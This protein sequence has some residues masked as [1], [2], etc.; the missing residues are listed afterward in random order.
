LVER[1]GRLQLEGL[2]AWAQ[3]KIFGGN[4]SLLNG[5]DGAE[6]R[7]GRCPLPNQPQRSRCLSVVFVGI[8]DMQWVGEARQTISSRRQK[9]RADQVFDLLNQAR[10][11]R[12]R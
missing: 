7:E 2:M 5:D 12:R 10:R 3:T 6:R 8:G 1:R 4:Q 11:R 9:G